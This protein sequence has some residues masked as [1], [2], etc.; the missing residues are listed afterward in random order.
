MQQKI[1]FSQANKENM[2]LLNE[3]VSNK[4]M[5]DLENNLIT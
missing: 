3:S 1:L 4:C 2:S 5:K